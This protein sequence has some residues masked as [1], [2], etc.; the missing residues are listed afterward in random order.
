MRRRFV[1]VGCV[2][3]SCALAV[4]CRS[5]PPGGAGEAGSSPNALVSEPAAPVGDPAQEE[6]DEEG[7]RGAR[8][9]GDEGSMGRGRDVDRMA[10]VVGPGSGGSL[11]ALG[12]IGGKDGGKTGIGYGTGTGGS[13]IA[14]NQSPGIYGAGGLGLGGTG[15]PRG[16]GGSTGRHSRGRGGCGSD[17]T[18]FDCP[19]VDEFLIVEA[20]PPAEAAESSEPPPT[21]QGTLRAKTTQGDE[22]GDFPL[23]HTEVTSEISGMIA[24][25]TVAQVYGNPFAEVIEAVYVFPLPALGAVNDFVMQIGD[26]KIVGLIRPRAEAERIY[27]EARAAGQTASLLT[28]ERSNIFTQSVANIEPGGTVKIEITYFERLI[29]ESGYYE[30]VFPMVVGPRYIPGEPAAPAA[31]AATARPDD[32]STTRPA[33][34]STGSGQ[35][36]S[37]GSGQ[38]PSTGSGQGPSAGSGQGP[39]TSS[40]QA[41]GT[42][43]ATTTVPDADRITPPVLPPGQRSGHDI[44]LTV[45]LDAGLPIARLAVPTHQ[46]ET[47]DLGAGRRVLKLAAAD[48]IPNRDFVLRW[49]VAGADTQFGVL[50]HRG[51]DGGYLTLM[52]QPPA[53]PTDD[54]VVPREITFLLD[55]SGSMSGVPL[56]ISTAVVRETLDR[57]RPDDRFN[58]FVFAS[59]NGQLW[60]SARPKTDANVAAA[61]E[62]LDNLCGGGGTEMLAGIRR[63]LQAEHDPA[64]LQMYVFLT[65]G[66]VGD[67]ERILE[68]VKNDRGEARFFMFGI[69]SSVN[70]YLVDGIAEFGGGASDV[71]LNPG[72][73][74]GCRATRRLFAMIDSPVLVDVGID[75]NGLPVVDA[76]PSKLP[77]LFAGQTVSLVARATGSGSGTAYVTGRVGSRRVRYPV[78]VVLPERE[79]ANGA[80]APLWARWRIEDLSKQMVGA[81]ETASAEL[82]KQITDLAVE[83]R[84]VSQYTAF[85]AVDE[86][87]VVGNGNPLRVIQPVE[88]P[89]GMSY[90]G[91]FGEQPV[92]DAARIEAWGVN[93]QATESGKVRVGAVTLGS[94]AAE[95]GVQS[96]AILTTVNRTVVNDL[97]HLEGLLLQ[98][99][100]TSVR[101]GF[102]PGGEV[103]L[104]MP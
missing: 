30:W 77:D 20:P 22:K 96:G 102:E 5:K 80:L 57:L 23:Q 45:T 87:R 76:Y 56:G 9:A 82:E 92:G 16:S 18:P 42:S 89:A 54:Q 69:G 84:L 17:A 94:P 55:I 65:D 7:G 3:A 51:D 93:L 71:V 73:A 60:E 14:Q 6:K 70:R 46:V 15:A 38:G 99:T 47:Q 79:D 59:G 74:E 58:I 25:T 50:T 97:V 100:G 52:M 40:G 49:S 66:L 103:E 8:A 43:P 61:R 29:Y 81:D 41:G 48:T 98:A 44:G 37:T 11:Q 53:E 10:G 104:P 19:D 31:G 28:Q 2:V 32:R 90:E 64:A 91:V 26:R 35:G 95:A 67:E 78:A 62:Y 12:Y 75:W 1:L 85:V 39:S 4:D 86:S 101:V 27:A 24:R 33:G 36:P 63:A 13:G 88:L 21:T 68:L 83:F 72:E 34:P